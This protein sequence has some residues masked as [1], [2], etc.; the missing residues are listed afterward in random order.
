MNILIKKVRTYCLSFT[1]DV[2]FWNY[3]YM[4]SIQGL[5]ALSASMIV[6]VVNS[7]DTREGMNC[8]LEK[9]KPEWKVK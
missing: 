1:I 9:R 6:P 4:L 7:E 5:M 3:S 8:F 2:E